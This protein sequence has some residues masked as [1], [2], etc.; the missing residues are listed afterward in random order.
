MP[1]PRRGEGPPG[2]S[3]AGPGVRPLLLRIALALL[4]LLLVQE[5]LARAVFPLP[6]V[7]N[8]D[9]S[10][11]SWLGFAPGGN[12]PT[13]LGNASFTWASRR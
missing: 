13:S 10:A 6:E 1:P 7:L 8:F 2:R 3:L 4:L 9:R 12:Q 5:G 11:Y